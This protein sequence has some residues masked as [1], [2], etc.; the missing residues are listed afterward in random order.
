DTDQEKVAQIMADYDFAV[1]PVVDSQNRLVGIV[2]VDDVLDVVE[3]EAT[4]DI[5]RLGAA[6]ID[7]DYPRAQP[8]LLFRKRAPWLVALV[9][10]MTLTVQVLSDYEDLL[11]EITLLSFFLP[12]LIG[13][14]GNV[15]AQA[16]TLVV[17]SLATRELELRD[18]LR[19]LY[20]ELGTG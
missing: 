7:I 13:T 2:T 5:L 10:S 15:G 14:G 3:D 6:P 11:S 19:V 16:A 9:I 20:K 8:W 12:L 4:E 17:R 18:Y 1:L